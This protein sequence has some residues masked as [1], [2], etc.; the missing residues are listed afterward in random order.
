LNEYK[1]LKELTKALKAFPENV[2]KN[3]LTS[4]IRAAASTIQKEAKKNVPVKTGNLKKSIVVKKRK[5]TKTR[6]RFSIGIKRGTK[7]DAFYGH[8]IEFGRSK[9]A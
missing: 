6:I 8:I 1:G 9:N 3:I 2:Q 4:S 5:T 7:E